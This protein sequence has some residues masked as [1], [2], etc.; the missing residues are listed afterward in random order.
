MVIAVA[1]DENFDAVRGFA[2][3]ITFPVL[4]DPSHD[5]TELY[6]IS[7]VPTVVMIDEHDRIVHPNWSAFGTDTFREFTGIDSDR[8][9]DR[10]RDWVRDGATELAEDE[11]RAAVGDL[12]PDEE[13]ARLH[14]RIANELRG[15]GDD[16]GAAR[17]YE[18]AGALAPY[19]W[20]IRRAALPLQGR[21]PFGD[22]FFAL[23]AEADAAGRP[24]H[25]LTGY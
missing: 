2:A 19:D 8:Q 6:A 25:G 1:I 10:V 5:L 13:Q 12:T 21:D 4:M 22:D 20:T 23:H 3:G 24:Y 14:F 11:I 15:R 7:N 18:R 9:H 17:N 16:A